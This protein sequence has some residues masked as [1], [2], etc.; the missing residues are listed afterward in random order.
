MR[1]HLRKGVKFHN[2]ED[3]TAESVKVS[4]EHY[5]ATTSRSPWRSQLN[6]VKAVPDARSPHRRARHRA[7]QPAAAAQ[8][9]ARRWRCRPAPSA[10]LATAFPPTPSAPGQMRFVEYRPGQHV[11]MEVEPTATG[12]RSRRFQ[13]HAV[14]RSFPRTAPASPALEAG[15]VMMINNVPPDQVG[16]SASQPE[17][18]GA[19]VAVESRDLR[20]PAHRPQ[21]L[22]PTNACARR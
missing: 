22:Q 3:F 19:D 10:S 15:E 5:S 1:W 17:P 16:R 18:A 20:D 9:D 2:G 7:A 4:F 13:P 6:V 14:P 21:A 12:A 11:V 8:R